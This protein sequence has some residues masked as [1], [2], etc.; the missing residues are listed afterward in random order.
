MQ[1]YASIGKLVLKNAIGL[2]RNRKEIEYVNVS[3]LDERASGCFECPNYSLKQFYKNQ[4]DS[5]EYINACYQCANCNHCVYKT[6]TEEKIKYINEKNKY[7]V[8]TGYNA[9]LKTNGIKL[10]IVL[11]MMHPNRFGTIFDLS[12]SQLKDILGCDRK[13]V[14]AN[15]DSLKEYDYI[16]YVKAE[17]RG[18]INVIL[19]G[20]ESYFKP[21]REGGR[22]YMVFSEKL[23]TALL[24]IKDLTTL[25]IFL[26]QLIDTDNHSETEH[27]VFKKSYQDLLGCLPNYYKPNTVRKGLSV[28][29]DNPI[30][31]L[32][33]G[34]HVTFKLNP[35]Y[36]A[37]LV[38]EQ[39]ITDSRRTITSYIEE[40]NNNFDAINDKTALPEDVLSEIYY[41]DKR[42]AHY[43]VLS[44]KRPDIEDLAK[45]SW[46][47]S[48]YDILD[49]IDF[50]Y[51]NYTLAHTPI[52]NFAGL[53]RTLI[54]EIRDSRELY[55]LAA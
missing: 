42:P 31:T 19:K 10:L 2:Q 20:Y 33:I 38:K 51:M 3:R 37:K 16:D 11:H 14:L 29:L 49:A 9:T 23:V 21:A 47:F 36:N 34:E 50:I 27:K 4:P 7:G 44:V 5:E 54:P 25:R 53:V 24:E 26:H 8:K 1:Q 15:L 18:F 48:L 35:D 12:I 43:P 32:S 28:N 22:G 52:D 40:L 30:F 13:T 46:Q 17:K 45:L 55:K 41:K 6:V 39:L